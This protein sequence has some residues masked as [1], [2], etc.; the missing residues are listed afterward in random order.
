MVMGLTAAQTFVCVGAVI[1]VGLL[2][3]I[4]WGLCAMAGMLDDAE[5]TRG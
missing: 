4:A 2:Y 3:F 1:A 5:G